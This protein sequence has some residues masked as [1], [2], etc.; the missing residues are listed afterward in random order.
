[1]KWILSLTLLIAII[2]CDNRTQPQRPYN[3]YWQDNN[4]CVIMK[5]LWG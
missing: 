2:S 3:I 1:M 5:R 4:L